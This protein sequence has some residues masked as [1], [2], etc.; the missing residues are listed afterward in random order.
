MKQ[1]LKM[2]AV[3]VGAILLMGI[4]MPDCGGSQA[5]QQQIDELKTSNQQLKTKMS[6]TESQLKAMA[7]EMGQAKQLLGQMTNMLTTH[8]SALAQID[9][10]LKAAK[11][12]SPLTTKKKR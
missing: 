12:P 4:A 7:D 3:C 2:A 11:K 9:E 1:K 5:L 6:S 8:Q 10:Q